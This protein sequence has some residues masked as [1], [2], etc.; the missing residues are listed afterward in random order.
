MIDP[1]TFSRLDLRS[2]LDHEL[3]AP[4]PLLPPRMDALLLLRRQEEM[5]AWTTSQVRR[6]LDVG[7]SPADVVLARKEWRGLRPLSVLPLTDRVAYR[8]L[9]TLISDS[10][11]SDLAARGHNADFKRAPLGVEGAA[12]VLQTDIASYYQYIDHEALASELLAQTGDQLAIEA[13]INLLGGLQ[14]RGVGIPQISA[15]SDVLGDVYVDPVRRQLLRM[16]FPTFRYADDFRVACTTL[17]SALSALE[18][19]DTAVRELGLTLNERKTLTFSREKY[20]SSLDAFSKMEARLFAARGGAGTLLDLQADY[21][22]AGLLPLLDFQSVT[23]EDTVG[24]S[25]EEFDSVV[26]DLIPPSNEHSTGVATE[27]VRLWRKQ[28][29]D[30][31]AKSTRDAAIIQNLLARALPLLGHAG[32]TR[33]SRY[34]PQLLTHEPALTPQISTYLIAMARGGTGNSRAARSALNEVATLDLLSPWQETWLAHVA[35][36]IPARSSRGEDA[37]V[38]WLDSRLDS[39]HPSVAAT[40]A[41]SLGRIRR[42]EPGRLRAVVQR[43][44]PSWRSLAFLGLVRL[45]TGSAAEVADSQFDRILLSLGGR[46]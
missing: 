7:A 32:V 37:Y 34:L 25:D 42:G 43:A 17:G 31:D 11:P 46:G 21:G 27:V 44:G 39:I 12:F 38:E 14:G 23:D 6:G 40:A 4:N 20:E 2:A 15:S 18:M 19:C 28:D 1:T 33:P 24:L 36:S 5:L 8:A 16:G 22:L 29:N 41:L 45:D 30:H 35:G 3:Q 26:A 9:T 13:L 10:L